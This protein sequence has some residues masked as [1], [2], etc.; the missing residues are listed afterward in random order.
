MT[1]LRE[2]VAQGRAGELDQSA[3]GLAKVVDEE[4]CASNCYRPQEQEQ[5]T[6]HGCVAGSEEAE[7]EEIN[8]QPE[9]QDSQ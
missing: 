8:G 9:D 6:N 2:S 7:A 1:Q 5:R 4:D 3:E